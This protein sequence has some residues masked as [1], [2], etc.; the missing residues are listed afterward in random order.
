MWDIHANKPIN[1]FDN[2]AFRIRGAQEPK[3]DCICIVVITSIRI[4][5]Y[6]IYTVMLLMHIAQA[7]LSQPDQ[8][9]SGASKLSRINDTLI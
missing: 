6:S 8:S 9:S 7:Q 3:P 5:I 2:S 4:Q 1:K